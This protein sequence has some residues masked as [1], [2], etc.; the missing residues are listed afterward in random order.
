MTDTKR[1]WLVRCAVI[2][3]ILALAALMMILGR[4]HTVYFDNKTL[5]YNGETYSAKQRINVDVTGAKTAKLSKRDRGMATWIGQNFTMDLEIT[6]NKG[7]EPVKKTVSL[8]LPY[9]MDGVVLNLPGLLADLPREAWMSEF[10][11]MAAE[12]EAEEAEDE[13]VTDDFGLGDF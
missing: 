13:I 8:K 4:G 2:V 1:K 12:T 9:S 3:F 7:D 6:E 5:E 11:S 10:V